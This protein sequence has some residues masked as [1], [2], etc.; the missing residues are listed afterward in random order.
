M[1]TKATDKL[2]ASDWL[3]FFTRAD[4]LT[5]ALTETHTTKA[6]TI[7][8]GQFLS[9]NVDRPVPIQVGGRSGHAT[10]RVKKGKAKS[11]LYFFEITWDAPEI[12][13]K[14]KGKTNKKAKSNQGPIKSQPTPPKAASTKVPSTKKP[15]PKG[16]KLGNDE[17]WE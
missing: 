3:P 14:K 17:K 7:K 13:E 9:P 16:S 5:Q 2:P 4:I 8:I 15:V 10:L 6:K 11:K 1:P 12:S